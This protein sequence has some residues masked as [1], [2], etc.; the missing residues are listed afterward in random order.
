MA[1]PRND[2]EQGARPMNDST[3]PP[4]RHQERK[5]AVRKQERLQ[6]GFGLSDWVQ[7]T[8]VS[9]DLAQRGGA[10]LRHDIARDEIAQHDSIHDAWLIVNHKVYN[11]TP[12]LHYHPGGIAI[13]KHTLGKDATALFD[14]YHPWVNIDGYVLSVQ[15]Y[16]IPQCM[17]IHKKMQ[18]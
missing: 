2:D 13:M 17:Y 1:T 5:V 10:G 12:Y 16:T 3:L 6:K 18:G 14:K 15:P 8:H 7:L 9:K 11:V 4:S